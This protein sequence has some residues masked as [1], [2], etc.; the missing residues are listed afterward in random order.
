MI[1]ENV[2]PK[3][4][5]PDNRLNAAIRAAY[6]L[7]RPQGMGMFHFRPGPM[8][9]DDAEE[10]IEAQKMRGRI[11]LDYVSGRAVKLT[12]LRDDEGWFLRDEGRWFD[13]P[14]ADFTVLKN[15]INGSE[16]DEPCNN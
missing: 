16:G 8:R 15:T 1:D 13:H 4:R 11:S 5:I 10:I 7:S 12:I 14:P 6:S 2:T 9:P 3:F